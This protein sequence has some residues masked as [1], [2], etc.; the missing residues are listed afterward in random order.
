QI[1][2]ASLII[3]LGLLV[4]DP[5]VANDAMKQDLALGHPRRVAA[6]LG[7][8]KLATAI[9]FATLTNIAAYFPLVALPG[10]MGQFLFSPAIGV[11]ASLVASRLVS[12]TFGPMLGYYLLRPPKKLTP[13]IAERRKH[14]VPKRY[15]G[16]IGWAIDHRW[17]ALGVSLLMVAG[18]LG[19][20][21][22]LKG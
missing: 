4:D 10:A 13:T 5:V 2:I 11:C 3:A 16:F 7:P 18:G 12:L 9:M 8:T 22:G 20:A 6:W 17:I 19:A 1:S 14:G 15:A 21:S